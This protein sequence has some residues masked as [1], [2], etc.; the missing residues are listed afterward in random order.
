MLGVDDVGKLATVN[1]LIM[2]PHIDPEVKKLGVIKR[3][4]SNN[5]S[6]GCS[7]R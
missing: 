5:L 1:K 4:F 2:Y 6:N 7:P 3:I